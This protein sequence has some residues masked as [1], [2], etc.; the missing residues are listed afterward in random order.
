MATL[1]LPNIAST[2]PTLAE[3]MR[4]CLLRAG[5]S[6]TPD[7]LKLALGNPKGW[8]GTAYHEVLESIPKADLKQESLQA[9]VD[10]LWTAAIAKQLQNVAGHPLNRRYGAPEGWPGYFLAKASVF[11]RAQ[12]IVTVSPSPM[13]NP[14]SP[15]AV[16]QASAAIREVK[17]AACNGK[18][19]GRPD[20]IRP[21]EIVDFKSGTV[22][23][24]DDSASS[25]TV[26]SAYVRQLRI[27]GYLVKQ[28]LGWWPQRGILLPLVGAGVEVPLQ[29]ATCEEEAQQ[30]VN[31][32][33]SY[34]T[35]ATSRASPAGLASPG[36]EV[37]K[38]CPFKI[39][40]SPFWGSATPSWAGQLDGEAIEAIADA[41]PK[42]IYNGEALALTV[43]IKRGTVPETR[44]S[45]APINPVTHPA[46]GTVAPTETIRITGLRARP[47][48]ALVPVQRTV[49]SSLKDTPV[50]SAP[51]GSA[52]IS[53]R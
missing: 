7:A 38:W 47:D 31:L 18:L 17:F 42:P 1:H 21:G 32:L 9:A 40:C 35:K 33:E 49:I 2:S 50:L 23:E 20:V 14:G 11:L 6:R 52:T 24:L 27:Y 13:G 4:A 12:E 5:L 29:E 8:L 48:G 34:N 16:T 28:T 36:P 39:I 51:T 22:H 10:R 43:N 19:T 3:V 45:I 41:P 44:T 15:H 26:K 46:A 30:A 25:E 37:C 53:P